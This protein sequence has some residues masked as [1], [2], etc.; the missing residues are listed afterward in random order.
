MWPPAARALRPWTQ[1]THL[2]RGTRVRARGR[3]SS[4]GLGDGVSPSPALSG[5]DSP[6]ALPQEPPARSRRRVERSVWPLPS[7]ARPVRADPAPPR[8]RPRARTAA[9][10]RPRRESL[11][12]LESQGDEKA[13]MHPLE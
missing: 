9:E 8:E 4:G 5:S 7:S 10:E 13:L 11:L 1:D 3:G 2:R 12:V 6:G